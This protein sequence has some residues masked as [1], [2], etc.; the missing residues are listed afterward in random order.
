MYY[1]LTKQYNDSFNWC[2][3]AVRLLVMQLSKEEFSLRPA[4]E[5]DIWHRVIWGTFIFKRYLYRL[6]RAKVLNCRSQSFLAHYKDTPRLDEAKVPQPDV[7]AR[8]KYPILCIRLEVS[9]LANRFSKHCAEASHREPG[10]AEKVEELH[11]SVLNLKN[12]IPQEWCPDND[13][14]ADPEMHHCVLMLHYEYH[15]L[16]IAIYTVVALAPFRGVDIFTP[17]MACYRD[18]AIGRIRNSR[19][20]LQT[21]M[22][23]DRVKMHNLALTQWY[24]GSV[25]VC[26]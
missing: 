13:I 9:R 15:A 2:E 1:R 10:F 17:A 25:I 3:W 4:H 6:G 7:A 18:Q 11:N 12:A 26:M 23:M 20:L 22:A 8:T 16:V 19:R 5:K 14:F 21:L 24:G